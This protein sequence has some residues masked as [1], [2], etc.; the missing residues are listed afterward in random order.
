M[1]IASCGSNSPED[2]VLLRTD[3]FSGEVPDHV[4]SWVFI[5]DKSG[6]LLDLHKTS[7]GEEEVLEFEG[8]A[9]DWIIVTDVSVASFDNNGITRLQHQITSYVGV[10][11]G[12][13]YLVSERDPGQTTYSDTLGRASLVLNNYNESSDP[14]STIGFSDSYNSYNN[15][16]DLSTITYDGFTFAADMILRESPIDI[17]VSAYNGPEPVYT[18]LRDVEVGDDIVIDFD[19]FSPLTKV[20]INKPVNNAYI[21]GQIEPE[22]G[23]RGYELS[24]SEYRMM[25]DD[26]DPSE[27]VTIGY[28][29]GFDYYDTYA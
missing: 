16:L 11:V 13:T 26:Y 29:D 8:V 4:E 20:S 19:S 25:S 23:G 18:W 9:D 10:P 15:W 21:Q 27:T 24:R 14:L 5:S 28:V 12:E 17:F 3:S 2:E 22:L 6:R 1:I 7:E